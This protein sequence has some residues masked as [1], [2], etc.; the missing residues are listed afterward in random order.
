MMIPGERNG[1]EREDEEEARK[2][3]LS[4]KNGGSGSNN[5]FLVGWG[6]VTSAAHI[7]YFDLFTT[8]SI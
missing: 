7:M 8:S 5:F 6:P 4:N 1:N 3:Q 2:V